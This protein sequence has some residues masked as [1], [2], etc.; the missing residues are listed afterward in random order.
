MSPPQHR[1]NVDI[2]LAYPQSQPPQGP[3]HLPGYPS[4]AAFI[5]ADPDAAIYRTFTTLSARNL[6]YQQSELHDLESQLQALD[7]QDAADID[8][9]EA[10]KAARS[11]AHY[12][13]AGNERGKK[14]RELQGRIAERLR[15]YRES[16]PVFF[17]FL[18]EYVEMDGWMDGRKGL[19]RK[20]E[21]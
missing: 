8:N 15:A 2:E 7:R 17:S 21:N 12:S 5:H 13:D 6:L 10:Q 4:F 18:P 11:W 1:Q 3:P 14:H 9:E 16:F 19:G 20:R